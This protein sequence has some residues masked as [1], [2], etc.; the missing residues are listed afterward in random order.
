VATGTIEY[1]HTVYQDWRAALF[2]DAGDA[3][4][5]WQQYQLR[6]GTGFGARWANPIGILGADLAFGL[7]EKTWRFYLSMGLTF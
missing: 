1:Q 3:T 5:S 2:I 6:V 4:K 7:K